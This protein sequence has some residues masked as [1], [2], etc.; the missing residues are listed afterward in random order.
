MSG[1]AFSVPSYRRHKQSGQAVVALSDGFGGRRD[2]LLG[3]HGT[4]ESRA[5]RHE[6]LEMRCGH[7][8]ETRR[9]RPVNRG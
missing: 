5:D 4:L 7:D 6:P 3:T 2:V 8:T 1:R 9:E